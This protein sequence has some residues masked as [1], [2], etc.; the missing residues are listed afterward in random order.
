MIRRR[1][2]AFLGGGR[3]PIEAGRNRASGGG[4]GGGAWAGSGARASGGG[5]KQAL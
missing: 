2:Q 5:G 3:I 1:L 4:G